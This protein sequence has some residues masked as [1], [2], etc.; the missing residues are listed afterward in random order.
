MNELIEKIFK[1]FEV[2]SESI[3]VE[4]LKYTGSKETYITYQNTNI[5]NVLCGDDEI[6]GYVDYYDFDF[7]SK[8]NYSKVISE[9]K[10][11]L[12]ANGFMWLPSMSSSD[13]YEVDT[14]YY[15]KTLCFA[16]GRMV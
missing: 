3:P 10:K 16:K 15:H 11:I 9:A 12:K 8:G 5:D 6:I 2:D 13:D 4:F 7:Y 14:C 1:D